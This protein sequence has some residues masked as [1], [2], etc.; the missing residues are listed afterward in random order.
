MYQILQIV[1]GSFIPTRKPKHLK[2]RHQYELRM[3]VAPH[4][5]SDPELGTSE[6]PLSRETSNIK[7]D[8]RTSSLVPSWNLKPSPDLNVDVSVE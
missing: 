8:P 7:H 4:A 6:N 5:S 1:M 3:P 2:K